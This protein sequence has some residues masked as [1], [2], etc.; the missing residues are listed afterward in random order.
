LRRDHAEKLLEM[1]LVVAA[2]DTLTFDDLLVEVSAAEERGAHST[3]VVVE[4]NVRGAASDAHVRFDGAGVAQSLC[5]GFT[6]D[7]VTSTDQGAEQRGA[8]VG[9]GGCV[10]QGGVLIGV[11]HV[12]WSAGGRG[13]SEGENENE[14]RYEHRE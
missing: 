2:Q 7:L 12:A 11:H 5:D 8:D 6:E 1:S 14:R 13:E 4:A 9:A 10:R 3:V